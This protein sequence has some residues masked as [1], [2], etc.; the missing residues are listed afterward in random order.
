MAWLYVPDEVL[1]VREPARLR[2]CAHAVL[3][4][5]AIRCGR[6]GAES[7]ECWES[8]ES[9]ADALGVHKDT[10]RTAI[11]TLSR[12]QLIVITEKRAQ[13]GTVTKLSHR[14]HQRVFRDV[15]RPVKKDVQALARPVPPTRPLP[16]GMT[17]GEYDDA[18]SASAQMLEHGRVIPGSEDALNDAIRLGLI[19]KQQLDAARRNNHEV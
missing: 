16:M 18:K 7:G 17:Q 3:M 5:I 4:R 10:V 13:D 12:L 6:V 8:M 19:T 15:A 2:G 14:L 9:M 11:R 1:Y